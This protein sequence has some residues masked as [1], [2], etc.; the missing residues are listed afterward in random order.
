MFPLPR[1]RPLTL[2]TCLLLLATPGRAQL[3]A[4]APAPTGQLVRIQLR[5]PPVR[6]EGRLLRLDRDS[7]VLSLVGP[8]VGRTVPIPRSAISSAWVSAGR[9]RNT[10]R[11]L[12]IG[13]LAGGVGGAIIGAV[14]YSPCES[15]GY[16]CILAPGS[17]AQA[18]GAG[19]ALVGTL[20]LVVGGVAG[21][22]TVRQ[23]WQ[24]LSLP[25]SAML[26]PIG[27]GRIALRVDAPF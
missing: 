2:A 12:G 24:P 5:D 21:W 18:A 23:R 27:R 26:A 19:A 9:S 16:G 25:A 11:G 13:L 10:L 22:A 4:G 1:P 17:R 14:T 7:V 3:P 8:G 20:G 15:Q 6:Y